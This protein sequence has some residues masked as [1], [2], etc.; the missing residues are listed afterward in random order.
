MIKM[1]DDQSIEITKLRHEIDWLKR[2]IF[3]QK[4]ERRIDLPAGMQGTLGEDPLS[5]KLFAFINRRGTQMRVL[6]WD[7]SGWC[8]WAK[9]LEQGRFIS[10]LVEREHAEDGLHR[11]QVA[12]RRDRAY[13]CSKAL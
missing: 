5:G 4:S 9:R 13:A 1:L 11:A 3:G 7:R 6:V 2:Q 10:D 8:I 12:A